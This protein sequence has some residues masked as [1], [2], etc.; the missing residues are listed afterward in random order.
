MGERPER[1][2]HTGLTDNLWALM[3]QCWR[4]DRSERPK[5]SDVLGI[6]RDWSVSLLHRQPSAHFDVFISRDDHPVLVPVLPPARTDWL[7]QITSEVLD[8]TNQVASVALFGSIGVGKT[9]VARTVLDHNQTKAKFGDNRY[10]IR[11]DVDSLEGF[12][13]KVSNAIHTDLT[14]LEARLQSSPPLILL[15]DGVDSILD[16]LAPVVEEVHARIEEFGSYKHVC[17]VT[18]SR[19]YPNIHGFHRVEVPTPPEDCAQQIFY[20]LCNLGRSP[21]LDIL[22][23]K[24][25]FHP[26]S[27]EMLAR[28][29]RENCWDEEMLLKA[30]GDQRGVLRTSYYQGLKDTIEPVFRSPRIQELGTIARDVLEAI[31]SFRSGIGENQLEGIFHGTGGVREVVDVL[32]IFSLVH[33]QDGVLKMLSPLQFYFLESMLVYAETEEVIRWGPDCMPAPGGMSSSLDSS[34]GCRVTVSLSTPCL[35]PGT[36]RLF[37]I[38][39]LLMLYH[40]PAKKELD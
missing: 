31:A 10:F 21:A 8:L 38:S 6:L 25:D 15:L 1:P 7:T 36:T 3:K 26:F 20:N 37:V 11:C 2:T 28:S 27:I 13:E 22:V 12:I 17:L 34:H 24:L 39:L 32:C 30:W 16:P 4:K 9:F 40:P 18:T 5:I 29:T 35:W 19:V 14:Q 23:A 33:R